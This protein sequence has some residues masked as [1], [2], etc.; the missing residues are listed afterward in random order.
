MALVVF[1]SRVN[2]LTVATPS[3]GGFVIGYD[4]TDGILKQKNDQGAITPIAGS[5]SAGSLSQTLAKGTSTGTY[6]IDLGT[7][8][9]ISSVMGGGQLRLDNGVGGANIVNLSTDS[10]AFLQSYLFMNSN[11]ITLKSVN[12]SLLLNSTSASFQLNTSN[13]MSFNSTGCFIN[14]ASK[15]VLFLT[16]GTSSTDSGNKAGVIISS[17]TSRLGNGVYNTV[18]LGGDNIIAANA[19]S[20]YVPNLYIKDGGFIKGTTG[21]GQL[22]FTNINESFLLSTDKLFGILSSSSSLSSYNGVFMVDTGS[23]FSTPST[24]Y[25]VIYVGS[26]NTTNDSG[27]SNVVVIGGN[28]LSITQSN[29]T[30]I[31]GSVSIG[32]KYLLPGD[33]GVLGQV[34]QTDGNGNTFWGNFGGSVTEITAASFS[35]LS[36]TF[37][38]NVTYK[39][40]DADSS[41]YGGT[42]IYLTTNSSGVLNEKG[43]GK[44]YNP[45]YDQT[46]SG[47]FIWSSSNSYVLDDYV[48]WGGLAWTNN[49]GTNSDPS[50]DILTLSSSEWDLVTYDGTFSEFYYNIAYD[51]I[52][53][54]WKNNLIIYRNEKNSNIVSTSVEDLYWWIDNFG[55]SPIRVF[56]WGNTF[57]LD[58]TTGNFL[59]T[60]KGIGTNKIIES[61]NENINFTGSYQIGINFTNR[62]YQTSINF[63]NDSYQSNINFY[64]GY[65]FD[66]TFDNSYQDNIRLENYNWNRGGDIIT[67]SETNLTFIKNK[68]LFGDNFNIKESLS[69]VNIK[70]TL[71]Y[72]LAT[73]S[74]VFNASGEAVYYG[75]AAIGLTAGYLYANIGGTWSEANNISNYS[76]QLGIALGEN[77]SIDGLLIKGFVH[78]N[79]TMYSANVGSTQ[80]ISDVSAEFTEVLPTGSSYI[81]VI[82]H[83]VQ[84]RILYF[85]PEIS[86]DPRPY[87]VYTAWITQTGTNAPTATVL[88]NTLGQT[89]TWS[90]NGVGS[91]TTN[92]IIGGTSE[93]LWVNVT[94]QSFGNDLNAEEHNTGGASAIYLSQGSFLGGA[95]NGLQKG[96]IEIR[97]YN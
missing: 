6:S 38:P 88:E 65:Q 39:V 78:A 45:K 13:I 5:N 42:E 46:V 12:A 22:Q 47:F 54:D 76:Y 75:T 30:Y 3:V 44:F 16:T 87:K 8:C 59:L 90:Y 84:D 21:L 17:S 96:Y 29:T 26:Y 43:V 15:R 23:T 74:G 71:N 33:D 93:N 63:I 11:S 95:V 73:A 1:E 60:N 52:K 57:N 72:T 9:K 77:P 92:D 27:L 37:E 28:T 14:L 86:Q 35:A 66:V 89:I 7:N 32:N 31:G 36:G 82:G 85:N 80:Y 20:V 50:I 91:F 81:R 69:N 55:Y 62:S 19:N 83:M 24:N 97:L 4:S 61:Y 68:H 58:N 53:Y 67:T 34:I 48:F 2:M 64:K 51:E 25:G 18:I 41:L 79:P 94:K 56:Q 49:S 40:L 70:G 10:G